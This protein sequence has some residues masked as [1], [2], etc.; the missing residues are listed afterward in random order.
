MTGRVPRAAGPAAKRGT[1]LTTLALAAALA[2]PLGVAPPAS[3][4]GT[5]PVLARSPEVSATTRLADRR[6]IVVGD[7]MYEGGAEDGSYPATG[8]HIHGE[9]GGFWSQPIKLLDGLW[10][11]VNGRWLAASRYSTGWGYARM[12]LGSVNGV[13][14]TRT[15]VMPDGIRAGLIGLTLRSTRARTVSLTM[16]AHSE[17][18]TA[19]PWTGTTPDALST[20]APDTGSYDGHGLVFRER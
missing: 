13:T 4:Q 17:L 18:M 8:W 7:R 2:V 3:A 19:Y 5:A 9:M 1:L 12:E 16:D 20:N 15:D 6:S 11:N 10:F 14:V